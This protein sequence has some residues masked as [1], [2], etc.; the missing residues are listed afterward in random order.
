MNE[1]FQ[2]LDII[3]LAMVA[4][5]IL[6]RLRS[7]LG[8]RTGQERRR[9]GLFAGRPVDQ[10]AEKVVPLP[11][12][13]AAKPADDAFAD[14][15]NPAVAAGL[16]QIKLADPTFDRKAFIEGARS[17][18]ELIVG[19]FA[20]GDSKTLRTFL[21]DEVYTSFAQSI[22]EREAGGQRLETTLV[23][24]DDAEIVEA[25]MNRRIAVITMRFT[26]HQIN[27]TYDGD[28]AVVD[29]DPDTPVE[30]VDL[31]TFERDTRS[32]DP[33]WRLTA[34]RVPE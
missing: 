12:K 32:R 25:E 14:E 10:G 27:V 8:R 6:L 33:N 4:A 3:F 16:R 9:G 13:L 11:K 1:G 21:A 29:G 20:A 17:A 18:F 7:V 23:S 19:A 22:A 28:G 30:V 5:F 31:W 24:L 2:F 15:K 26:S 34:T